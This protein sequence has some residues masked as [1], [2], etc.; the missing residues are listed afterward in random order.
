MILIL[1]FIGF[2]Y[3]ESE[4]E[5]EAPGWNFDPEF[6]SDVSSSHKLDGNKYI[7]GKGRLPAS[8]PI[9][10]NLI[11]LPVWVVGLPYRN[12][13]FLAVLLSNGEIQTF[14]MNGDQVQVLNIQQSKISTERSPVLVRTGDSFQF[15]EV[16]DDKAS[17]LSSPLFLDSI[18]TLLYIE[19]N[20]DLIAWKGNK[21]ERLDVDALPDSQ[22]L[23]D[24]QERVLLYSG[25]TTSYKHGILGDIIEASRITI[26]DAD[27]M[28]LIQEIK[29][30]PPDVFE[31]LFPIWIDIDQDNMREIITTVSN[32]ISGARLVLYD[33][34]GEVLMEGPP[35]GT[36]R[37]WRHQ[38]AYAP[39]QSNGEFEIVD[40]LTP[41]IG[42]SVEFYSFETNS[43]KISASIPGYSTHSIGSRNLD[44]A[45]AGDFDGDGGVEL[46]VP[47]QDFGEI[48]AIKHVENYALNIWHLSLD[49]KL[50]TNIAA[51]KNSKNR[52]VVACGTDQNLLRIWS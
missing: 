28:K 25:R 27:E 34:T 39:F 51:I 26:I 8:I 22:I 15:L 38:L 45:M 9:D 13:I 50:S 5:K 12:G 46:L 30:N 41:H 21:V 31:G 24:G 16:L 40:V 17:K 36:G 10:I 48:A 1:G 52:I 19:E 29:L 49:G 43:L 23:H 18:D 47:S 37:R 11:G 4:M 7:E 33:D 32:P 2:F 35:V 14:I 42:G 44:M 3:I 6:I 20:G